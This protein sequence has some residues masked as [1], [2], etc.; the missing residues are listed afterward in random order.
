MAKASKTSPFSPAHIP[1]F[2]YGW[3]IFFSSLCGRLISLPGISSG[4]RHA[5]TYSGVALG[6][7]YL[8]FGYIDVFIDS[9]QRFTSPALGATCVLFVGFFLRKLLGQNL[10]PLASRLMIL[11]WYD[12]KSSTMMGISGV[13]TSVIFG[14]I[15]PLTHLLLTHFG[16]LDT[17]KILGLAT[18]FG[19][20]PIIWGTYRDSP[21]SIGVALDADP[22][23]TKDAAP[24][25]TFVRDKTLGEALRTF[26]FWIVIAAIA[27]SVFITNGF[28]IHIVDIFREMHACMPNAMDIFPP[29][30]II[31]AVFSFLLG[32]FFFR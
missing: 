8:F 11:L 28:Q 21:Q 16:H 10:V 19:F 13:F 26:D 9:T 22:G 17:W 7:T 12:R 15:P 29:G 6:L 27:N 25:G 1:F 20:V 4:I 14:L 5:I 3:I 30:A 32:I 18:I 31:S 24:D 23:P 2:F